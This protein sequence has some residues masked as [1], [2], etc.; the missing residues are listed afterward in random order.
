MIVIDLL[1]ALYSFTEGKTL[2][3]IIALLQIAVL[4]VTMLIGSGSIEKIKGMKIP[5]AVFLVIACV[6]CIPYFRLNSSTPS[7]EERK[8]LV[9]SSSDMAQRIPEPN[10]KYGEISSDDDEYFD[11]EIKDF[12]QEKYQHYLSQCKK[13]GFTVDPSNDTDSYEAADQDGYVLEL[14]SDSDSDTMDITLSAP[15]QYEDITWP[16]SEFSKVLPAPPGNKGAVETDESDDFRILIPD[17]DDKKFKE[18]SKKVLAAGFNVDYNNDNDYFSGSNADGLE[19][20]LERETGYV[21]DINLTKS[22]DTESTSAPTSKP[23]TAPTAK[24]TPAPASTGMRP[25]FKAAMDSYKATIDAYCEFM[26]SYDSSD[27][28]M[29]TKYTQLYT[30]Y[31]DTMSKLDQV[32]EKELSPEEDSYYIKIMGE[33]TQELLETGQ[34]MNQ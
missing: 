6:L 19:V 4:V 34:S 29:V 33:V 13:K 18:Y 32:D 7:R 2:A 25:E 30:Q 16:V 22:E 3:G 23:T 10:S 28:A 27:T 1:A 21:M 11:A 8:K 12:D 14:S 17:I 31:L 15:A 5:Y 26:K 20:Y 9:W 24:A